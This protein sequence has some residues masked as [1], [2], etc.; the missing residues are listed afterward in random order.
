MVHFTGRSAN[1]SCGNDTGFGAVDR[2]DM[3]SQAPHEYNN[4]GVLAAAEGL[5]EGGC[6]TQQLGTLKVNRSSISEFSW[7]VV[8]SLRGAGQVDVNF[9]D[10][11]NN[12]VAITSKDANQLMTI[13]FNKILMH[14]TEPATNGVFVGPTEGIESPAQDRVVVYRNSIKMPEVLVS[15]KTQAGTDYQPEISYLPTVAV[16]ITNPNRI[17]LSALVENNT[18]DLVPNNFGSVTAIVFIGVSGG[19]IAN[20]YFRGSAYSGIEL[21]N[22]WFED[23][24][25]VYNNVTGN[26]FLDLSVEVGI[27]LGSDTENNIVGPGQTNNI[28]DDGKNFILGGLPT[29]TGS[30]N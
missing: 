20:N 18:I 2:V 8:S 17:G 19:S 25:T 1:D 5:S 14:S 23:S 26:I 11:E 29:V 3:V 13:Q 24:M 28:W 21:Y 7:G 27:F 15:S 30:R 16:N 9:N 22:A 10:F 12:I 4:T 6:N